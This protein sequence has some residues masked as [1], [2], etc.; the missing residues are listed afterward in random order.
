MSFAAK[1]NK[2]ASYR[3]TY[4][5]IENPQYLKLKEMYA[6]GFNSESN[7]FTVR[8][9]FISKGGRYGDSASLICDGYNV[10]LPAHM[11]DEI[12]EII[13]NQE[14]VQAINNGTVAAYVYEYENRNGGKSYSIRWVDADPLPF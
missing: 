6:K 4:Q 11:V 5:Q 8:G 7:T 2:S 9:A 14:D 3:F 1:H 12:R 10:N 13:E